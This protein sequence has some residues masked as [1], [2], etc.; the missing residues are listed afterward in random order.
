MLTAWNLELCAF[1]GKLWKLALSVRAALQSFGQP[2][3]DLGF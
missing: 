3:C 2:C 1:A